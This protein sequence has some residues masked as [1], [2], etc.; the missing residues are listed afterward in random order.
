MIRLL[1]IQYSHVLRDTY[2]YI[3]LFDFLLSEFDSCSY[4]LFVVVYFDLIRC[5]NDEKE[6]DE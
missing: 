1:V 2:A 3:V 6:I 4:V 5:V